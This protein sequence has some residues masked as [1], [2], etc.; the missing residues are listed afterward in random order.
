[1][2]RTEIKVGKIIITITAKDALMVE[3]NGY[4]YFIDD[5]TNEN[6]MNKYKEK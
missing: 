5:S 3:L 6:R 4:T 1:M 2:E